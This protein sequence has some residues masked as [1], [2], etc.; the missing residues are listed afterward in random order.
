MNICCQW[1][2]IKQEKTSEI[3]LLSIFCWSGGTIHTFLHSKGKRKL[4]V[5][6]KKILPKRKQESTVASLLPGG[7]ELKRNRFLKQTWRFPAF[8]CTDKLIQ[9]YS[10]VSFGGMLEKGQCNSVT[11]LSSLQRWLVFD[12]LHWTCPEAIVISCIYFI[13]VM[14]GGCTC[15]LLVSIK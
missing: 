3:V 1:R 9:Y 7:E 10:E 11:S 5:Q 8:W 12:S 4:P 6:K 15:N 13:E 2:R 14:H